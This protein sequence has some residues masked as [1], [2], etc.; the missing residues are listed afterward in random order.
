MADS[1]TINGKTH[2]WESVTITG[3]QGVFIGISEVNW[4]SSQKKKR[5]Y[6]KGATS[7]GATRGNYEATTSMTLLVSEYQDLA[8]ALAKGIYRTPFDVAV[9]FEPE[10]ATKHEVVIKQIM[11]D[12]LD[13]SAKQGD[14]EAT[15]KLSGTAL[16]ITRDGKADYETK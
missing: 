14:E 7:I 15:V 3:P 11:V 2:D 10:G 12:D 4:K 1:V 9:V 8:K 16:M 5:V 6:G 13:E